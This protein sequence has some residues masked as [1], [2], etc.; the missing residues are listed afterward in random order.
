MSNEIK[1]SALV[2][3]SNGTG[4][5]LSVE[6]GVARVRLDEDRS[7]LLCDFAEISY[8]E[9]PEMRHD[10]KLWILANRK[11]ISVDDFEKLVG[12]SF[13]IFSKEHKKDCLIAWNE[14]IS[15]ESRKNKSSKRP[16]KIRPAPIPCR[17]SAEGLQELRPKGGQRE[18]VMLRRNKVGSLYV[19]WNDI[20]TG[21]YYHPSFI[22]LLSPKP[23]GI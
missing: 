17:Y 3:T 6:K 20:K 8:A 2:V 11:E 14:Y 18:G 10:L 9:K 16:K 19:K 7:I 21:G 5:L 13:D 22:E 12:V 4:K 1:L 23:T 15:L